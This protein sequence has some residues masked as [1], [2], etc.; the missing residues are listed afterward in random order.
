M[1]PYEALKSANVRGTLNMIE[2]AHNST[3][4]KPLHFISSRAV[5]PPR[6]GSTHEE[7]T[8]LDDIATGHTGF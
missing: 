2:L 7:D 3:K 5:F 1:Y 4:I 6:P 8:P